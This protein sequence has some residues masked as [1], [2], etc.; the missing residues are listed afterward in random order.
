M[1]RS[2]YFVLAAVLISFLLSVYLWFSGQ[3][4]EGL[5]TGLWV[6]SIP[7]IAIYFKP[8]TGGRIMAE[9]VI[10]IIGFIVLTLTMTGPIMGG[11]KQKVNGKKRDICFLIWAVS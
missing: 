5:F 7:A 11:M 1:K 9:H 6:P 8:S 4:T 10:F 3:K 2:D